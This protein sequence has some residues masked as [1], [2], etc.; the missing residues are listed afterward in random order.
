MDSSLFEDG[1][2]ASMGGAGVGHM[3]MQFGISRK[4]LKQTHQ[5]LIANSI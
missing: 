3:A 5:K 4:Y 1:Q 2:P